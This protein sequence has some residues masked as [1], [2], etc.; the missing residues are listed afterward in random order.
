[1]KGGNKIGSWYSLT[2]KIH[3]VLGVLSSLVVFV[4]ALSGSLYALQ[5]ELQNIFYSHRFVNPTGIPLSPTEI[6]AI[7]ETHLGDEN[8]ARLHRFSPE[9]SVA[10]LFNN[11]ENYGYVFVNQYTGEVLHYQDFREDFFGL[12]L[13]IHMYLLLPP[14][15]GKVVVGTSSIVFVL[16]L[17]SGFFLWYKF[18][19]PKIWNWKKEA[20]WRRR[21][22]DFHRN[23]GIITLVF[24]LFFVLTGLIW[25]FKWYEKGAHFILSGGKELQELPSEISA[26]NFSKNESKIDHLFDSLV[27]V[28]GEKLSYTLYFPKSENSPLVLSVNDQ[29]SQF[30]NLEFFAFDPNS[31]ASLDLGSRFGPYTEGGLAE[32]FLKSNYDLHTGGFWGL[33]GKLVALL[34]SLGIASLPITGILMFLDKKFKPGNK[35][36][37]KISKNPLIPLI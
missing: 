33:G 18:K 26:S 11:P 1:M 6:Q 12:L 22:F 23:I 28:R 15:I 9:R 21:N 25:A 16:V 34:A 4:V 19:S 13:T 3:L 36:K 27:D 35:N 17:V 10:V 8:S 20:R 14:E 5:E 31:G 24:G 7:S 29:T 37:I 30:K 32:K 2:R